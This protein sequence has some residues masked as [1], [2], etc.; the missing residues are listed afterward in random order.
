MR[1]GTW[2]EDSSEDVA[3][4]RRAIDGGAANHNDKSER[5]LN[6]HTHTRTTQRNATDG[7]GRRGEGKGKIEKKERGIECKYPGRYGR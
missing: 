1:R 2:S 6:T 4:R 3:G 5:P 7:E